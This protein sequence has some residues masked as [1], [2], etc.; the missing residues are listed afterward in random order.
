MICRRF[1]G[2]GVAGS[3]AFLAATMPAFAQSFPSGSWLPNRGTVSYD[4]SLTQAWSPM[5]MRM[6]GSITVSS[7]FV[8]QRHCVQ[9]FSTPIMTCQTIVNGMPGEIHPMPVPP[10]RGAVGGNA[11]NWRPPMSGYM[12]APVPGFIAPPFNFS[13]GAPGSNFEMSGRWSWGD[14]NVSGW[15]RY[16]KAVW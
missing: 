2:L 15:F 10:P 7:R 8:R 5:R 9:K 16:S 12:M 6:I 13:N 14:W 3:V 4:M 1:S 11:F